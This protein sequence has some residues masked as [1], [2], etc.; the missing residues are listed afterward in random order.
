M[1]PLKT[2]LDKS[3][4]CNMTC[5]KGAFDKSVFDGNNF[6]LEISEENDSRSYVNIGADMVC[7]FLTK[8]DIRQYMSKMGSNITPYS[9]AIGEE[10]I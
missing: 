2:L 3:E 10:N 1:K 4:I 6:L 8:D 7:S 5:M 9:I